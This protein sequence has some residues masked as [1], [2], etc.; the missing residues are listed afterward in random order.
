MSKHPVEQPTP[1]A[2]MEGGPVSIQMDLTGCARFGQR[3]FSASVALRMTG[4]VAL[5]YTGAMPSSQFD[6][7][8][9]AAAHPAQAITHPLASHGL[10]RPASSVSSVGAELANY[11]RQSPEGLP[12]ALKHVTVFQ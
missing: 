10:I 11:G 1:I 6:T 5:E 4:Q 9:A 7:I 12:F 2:G 3:Y 8:R